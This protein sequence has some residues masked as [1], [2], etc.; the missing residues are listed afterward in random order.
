LEGQEVVVQLVNAQLAQP[1][2]GLAQALHVPFNC[3]EALHIMPIAPDGFPELAIPAIVQRVGDIALHSTDRLILIDTIYHHHTDQSGMTNRPTVVRT[4]QRVSFQVTRQQILFKAAVYHYCQYLQEGCGVSLD[5]YLWPTNHVDPRPVSHGS[6][7]TVDVPPPFGHQLDTRMVA[8]Q[9]HE[10]GTTDAMMNWLT[11]NDDMPEDAMQLTQIFA[12]KSVVTP[13]IK[14]RIRWSCRDCPTPVDV[15]SIVA[16]EHPMTSHQASPAVKS[17]DSLVPTATN[18]TADRPA[19]PPDQPFA[20]TCRGASDVAHAPDTMPSQRVHS[21][22]RSPLTPGQASLHQFFTRSV[23]EVKPATGTAVR[24]GQTTLHAFFAKTKTI[25]TRVQ[26]AHALSRPQNV[27]DVHK[28]VDST[29]KDT[30]DICKKAIEHKCSSSQEVEPPVYTT[31]HSV[32]PA[33]P[34]PRPAPRPAWRIHLANIFDELATVL[35]RETGPVMQVEVWYIH[36]TLFPECLAPRAVELDNIQELWYADLCN[37]W[38]D[39]IQRHEPLRVVNVLPT[40]PHQARP[41]SAAHLILEQGFTQDRIAV[42]FTAIFLGG[43]HL[44]LFQRVESSPPRLCTRD[45]I[46]RH[47]FQVQCAFRQCNMH[48]GR[49]RF[50]MDEPEEVFSGICAVLTIAPPPAEPLTMH[51]PVPEEP[52]GSSNDANGPDAMVLMQ[53][54]ITPKRPPANIRPADPSSSST[55]NQA[56][57][58]DHRIT[59]AAITEFRATLLWQLGTQDGTCRTPQVEPYQ[60]HTWYLNSDTCI[61]SE[62]SRVVQLRP[63]PHTWH[64]D[65][66]ERWIDR[67][68]SMYPV[69]LHVVTPNPPGSSLAPEAHVIVLQRPNPLWRSALLS[70]LQ[71][72]TD[73]WHLQFVCV[74]CWMPRHHWNSWGS[75]LELPIHP[76][77]KHT[78]WESKPS[79]DKPSCRETAHFLSGM[80][81]GLTFK[82]TVWMTLG[83]TR[84]QPF[85][86][87]LRQFVQSLVTSK[88]RSVTTVGPT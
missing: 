2:H 76:T 85:R 71:P 86:C 87:T 79:K 14:Q 1:T 54:P 27:Q 30:V 68:D 53:R 24:S 16:Y 34:R 7:A 47:G 26:P 62:E 22:A 69:H 33:L 38:F 77:Q 42:H 57:L 55:I 84:W 13:V 56:P 70:V 31:T 8:D 81:I 41:R 9:L 32:Q 11:D 52:S 37:V 51:M 60:V 45:M 74:P 6:Y 73:P 83:T 40:P 66:I 49:I 59:P 88:A 36:H 67:L 19:L 65:I 58:F 21:H 78:L 75:F 17:H 39:R 82:P 5:G 61:R 80:D 50:A 35:H 28:S 25:E 43:S 63:Q 23:P 46:V 72:R 29:T 44:G 4:V 64:R 20:E 15:D 10:D 3:I 12:A 18:T 48:S